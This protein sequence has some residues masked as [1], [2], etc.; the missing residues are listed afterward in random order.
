VTVHRFP[1]RLAA[2][3]ATLLA[4]AFPIVSCSKEDRSQVDQKVDELGKETEQKLDELGEQAEQKLKEAEPQ[5]RESMRD[6]QQAVGKGVE[7]AGELIQK[8]GEE[9][10]QEA[11]D[12]TKSTLPDTVTRDT[13]T[14]Q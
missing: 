12:T 4:L 2:L 6:A 13:A 8:G 10:Q 1:A 9:L 11:R 7:A 5:V 3:A 14:G